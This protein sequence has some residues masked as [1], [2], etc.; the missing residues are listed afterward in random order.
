MPGL[1]ARCYKG[2]VPLQSPL[3]LAVLVSLNEA[4]NLH[5]ANASAAHG[6]GANK[7][8]PCAR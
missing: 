7:N 1:R 2:T 8:A 6:K 3:N 5:T 4:M